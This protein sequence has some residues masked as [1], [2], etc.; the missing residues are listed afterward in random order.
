M[1]LEITN[2]RVHYGRAEAVKGISLEVDKGG[3]ITLIG[4]NGA[5]KTTTLRTISGIKHPTC[6]D[7]VFEGTRLNRLKPEHI[8]KLGIAHIPEGRRIFAEMTVMENLE[9]GA[10]LRKSRKE[11]AKDMQRTFEHFPVLKKK[12][13]QLA[14]SLSGGEQQM[15][16]IARALMTNPKLLLMDEPSMGLSPLMVKEVGNIIANIN[17]GGMTIILV[18]QNARLALKLALRAYVMEIG[19]IVLD[20]PADQ[21]INNEHVKK[22]Y[23][24]G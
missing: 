8:V 13:R 2:L 11:V 6:G 16:A 7:I 18:E 17:C 9:M 12:E 20:G 22:A 14:G 19:N 15:L 1:L 5:G 24:G 4:A 21:M 3:I 10:Y 23:L